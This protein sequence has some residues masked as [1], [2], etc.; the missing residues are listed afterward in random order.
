MFAKIGT[1]EQNKQCAIGCNY[2]RVG[3]L[4]PLEVFMSMVSEFKAERNEAFSEFVLTG[5]SAKAIA[6]SKKCGIKAPKDPESLAGGI[7]KIVIND[8]SFPENIQKLALKKCLALGFSPNIHPG[9]F[10]YAV[11]KGYIK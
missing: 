11:E 5:D 8:D 4:P 7:Y 1:R 9:A 2:G 3:P 10:S 6:F